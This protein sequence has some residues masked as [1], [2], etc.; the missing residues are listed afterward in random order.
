[1]GVYL[2]VGSVVVLRFWIDTHFVASYELATGRV[3]RNRVDCTCLFCAHAT[4]EIGLV[5]LYVR[6]IVAA[7]P[8]AVHRYA[9][10]RER[11]RKSLRT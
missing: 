5:Y 9:A 2:G 4:N 11:V 1:M 10:P 6:R 8:R 3:L 7:Q